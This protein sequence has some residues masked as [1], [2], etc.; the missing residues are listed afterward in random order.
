M[1]GS[2]PAFYLSGI[3]PAA[4]LKGKPM[5]SFAELW[6]RKGLVVIQFA[7]SVVFIVGVFVIN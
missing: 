4:T 6:I 1:A 3:E 5:T 2:Y 7:L